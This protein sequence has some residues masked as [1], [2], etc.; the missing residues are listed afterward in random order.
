MRKQDK[1]QDEKTG[2]EN[3]M[4]AQ[5]EKTNRMRKQNKKT[6]WENMMRKQ[7]EWESRI[8]KQDEKTWWEHRMRQQDEKTGWENRE[9]TGWENRMRKN[10]YVSPFNKYIFFVISLLRSG[11]WEIDPNYINFFQR[12][13]WYGQ[14]TR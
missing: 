4:R 14:L 1:K 5:D 3:K 7:T 6:G 8:R 11:S 12:I 13:V 9:K 2:W 10:S